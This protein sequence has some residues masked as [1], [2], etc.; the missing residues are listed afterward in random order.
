MRDEVLALFREMAD[1]SPEARARYFTEYRVDPEV[2]AEVDG[3]ST[4]SG[5]RRGRPLGV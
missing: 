3:N 5:A 1:L 2:R 4:A